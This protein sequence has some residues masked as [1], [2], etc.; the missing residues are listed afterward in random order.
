[1][2]VALL[3]NPQSDTSRALSSKV[4]EMVAADMNDTQT[5]V[6]VF[7]SAT[8]CFVHGSHFENQTQ[9]RQEPFNEYSF[10]YE[11]HQGMN[12]MDAVSTMQILKRFVGVRTVCCEG[13]EQRLV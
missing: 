3:V 2:F 10:E 9:S 4:V 13:M 8:L 12:I 5:L 1:M 11:K 7:E 6:C